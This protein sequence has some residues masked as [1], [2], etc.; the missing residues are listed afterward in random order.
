MALASRPTKTAVTSSWKLQAS[1][2]NPNNRVS[3]PP[4]SRKTRPTEREEI[5]PREQCIPSLL[6]PPPST[7]ARAR[8]DAHPSE[9]TSGFGRE[10]V[11]KNSSSTPKPA[12]SWV[13]RRRRG[14]GCRCGLHRGGPGL[15][16]PPRPPVWFLHPGEGR[17]HDVARGNCAYICA[18]IHTGLGLLCL[19]TYL[20]AVE[21]RARITWEKRYLALHKI[22]QSKKEGREE[23][24]DSRERGIRACLSSTFPAMGETHVPGRQNWLRTKN[25]ALGD[26]KTVV[27]PCKGY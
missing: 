27:T 12:L 17:C 8:T 1:K 13:L 9:V 2:R 11:G 18:Y 7:N 24:L 25:M 10:R 3:R 16:L 15:S 5:T 14:L 26:Q 22:S 20:L 23:R 6:P 21:T 19:H 4:R